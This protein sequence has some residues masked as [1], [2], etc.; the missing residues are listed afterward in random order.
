MPPGLGFLATALL[1]TALLVG[2]DA[3]ET[4]AVAFPD[5]RLIVTLEFA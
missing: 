3:A 5:V 1:A 4:L 2:V